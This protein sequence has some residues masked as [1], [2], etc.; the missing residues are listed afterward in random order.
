[1]SKDIIGG[2]LQTAEAPEKPKEGL[3]TPKRANISESDISEII[4]IPDGPMVAILKG[5]D[6]FG[7]LD[8]ETN[9]WRLA[10]PEEARAIETILLAESRHNRERGEELPQNIKAV[11]YAKV[12]SDKNSSQKSSAVY[13]F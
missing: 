10:D 5:T 1:M 13:K 7:I 9:Q 3:L 8:A 4:Q 2:L 12:S 6:G 11:D